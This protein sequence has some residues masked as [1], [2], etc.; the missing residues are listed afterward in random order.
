MNVY[1][2]YLWKQK[3]FSFQALHWIETTK[4]QN[5]FELEI[6]CDIINLSNIDILIN[7][8]IKVNLIKI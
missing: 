1:L 2:N 7:E 4:E 8:I 5:L 6:I 3:P